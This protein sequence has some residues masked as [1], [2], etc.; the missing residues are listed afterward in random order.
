MIDRNGEDQYAT[1][2][3]ITKLKGSFV[4]SL[5]LED[6]STEWIKESDLKV[7]N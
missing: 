6:G 1:V 2:Q 4:Y 3:S 7:I 5:L